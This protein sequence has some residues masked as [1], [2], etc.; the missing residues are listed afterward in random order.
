M[1]VRPVTAIEEVDLRMLENLG[2]Q[3]AGLQ[4]AF[5]GFRGVLHWF[6][7][8]RFWLKS[9]WLPRVTCASRAS[10]AYVDSHIDCL[11]PSGLFRTYM[12]RIK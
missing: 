3:N 10:P 1:V 9:Q 6:W 12:D 4:R 5:L 11:T 8:E 2:E 7:T